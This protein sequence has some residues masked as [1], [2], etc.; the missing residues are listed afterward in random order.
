MKLLAT[1]A[2]VLFFIIITTL[3]IEEYNIPVE[4]DPEECNIPVEY[5]PIEEEIRKTIKEDYFINRGIPFPRTPFEYSAYLV[6]GSVEHGGFMF[7]PNRN[8]EFLRMA[9]GVPV[10]PEIVKSVIGPKKTTL[11]LVYPMFRTIV[12]IESHPTGSVVIVETDSGSARW[13]LYPFCYEGG[14]GGRSIVIVCLARGQWEE[15]ETR[16]IY[17]HPNGMLSELE[18]VYFFEKK[19]PKP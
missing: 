3:S 12:T 16:V 14:L 15:V 5:D 19:A 9:K 1:L 4:Y 13:E 7:L 6:C 18:G 17:V 2:F 11:H 8:Y 10:F